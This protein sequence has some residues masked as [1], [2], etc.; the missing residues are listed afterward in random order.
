MAKVTKRDW[1]I[2]NAEQYAEEIAEILCDSTNVKTCKAFS[3]NSYQCDCCP[4]ESVCDDKNKLV[5]FL[6]TRTLR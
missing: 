5:H 2:S 1:T 3:K 4:L 6:K